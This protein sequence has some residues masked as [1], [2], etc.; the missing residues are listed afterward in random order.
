MSQVDEGDAL[1]VRGSRA[2]ATDVYVDGIRVNASQVQAA[3]VEQL[4]VI[5]GGI[6]AFYGDVTGGIISIT[7]KG[8]SSKFSGGLEVETSEYLDN[9]GY[10]QIQGNISGPLLK[11][12]ETEMH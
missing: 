3:D 7:T 9:F 5:T 10:N 2:N 1:T 8:P 4:Q 11:K 12:K 6:P